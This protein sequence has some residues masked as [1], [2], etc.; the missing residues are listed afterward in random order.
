MRDGVRP[1]VAPRKATLARRQLP[2]QRLSGLA[3]D[4]GLGCR[5]HGHLFGY[6]FCGFAAFC[7]PVRQT[8]LN[9]RPVL[10]QE[11]FQVQDTW[12]R[13]VRVPRWMQ[14]PTLPEAFVQPQL[15]CRNW[16][17]IPITFR[18]IPGTC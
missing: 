15:Q 17:T 9:R 2:T 12:P 11:A 8:L 18:R 5:L 6:G 1:L 3:A 13:L 14:P 7:Q 10:P 4:Q 16:K